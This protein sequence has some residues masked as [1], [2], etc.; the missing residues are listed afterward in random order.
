M[1]FEDNYESRVIVA[2][3]FKDRKEAISMAKL[4]TPELCKIKVGL[5]LFVSCGPS[6]IEELN[7]LGYKIFLDLKFHDITNT[8]I[9]SCIAASKLG[10]WML[11]V[12]SG[13]GK[14]M[15]ENSKANLL[16]KNYS[17]LL[18]GVTILTSLDENDINEIG[19]N[20][21]MNTQVLKMATLCKEAGLDGVVCS[22]EEAKHLK[23]K[24][25]K[26]FICVCPG[27]RSNDEENNDQKRIITP[28]IA[29]KN[30]ADYI[31]VGRPIIKSE[32]P[33]ESLINIKKEFDN[34]LKNNAK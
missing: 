14:K 1:S 4:F 23:L 30:G 9:Q 32:N 8:V 24:F 6:I 18:L 33:L 11:N 15:M 34:G 26:N 19:Y 5:E 21:D 22:A 3:D 10:V 27:I 12:H 20:T 29:A 25:P 28:T 31:V 17:T 2:L 13:G 7:S 16:K